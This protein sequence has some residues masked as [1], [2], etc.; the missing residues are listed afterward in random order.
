MDATEKTMRA[1]VVD[2]FGPA[3]NLH[4]ANVPL[5]QLFT[6]E[7]LVKVAAAGINPIDVKTR[8]GRGTASGFS[9]FPAVLGHDFAGVVAQPPYEAHPLAEGT[10]VFGMVS[11][12]RYSG[13]F[14]EYV[15]ANSLAVA[16]KPA[17]LTL[18]EAAAVPLA[19]LTAWGAVVDVAEAH[20]GQRMLIHAGAGG[21]GHFAVQFARHFGAE[22]ITTAS[23]RNADW[24]RE[25]GA[26]VVVD[27]TSTR[28]E[29]VV[30]DVDVVIDL[31]GNVH[32]DTA[33]RSLR[34]LKPGGLIVNVPSG[35]WPSMR[36][37]SDAAGMR[38]TRFKL[39]ADGAILA[40]I[41]ELIDAGDVRVN[42]DR[43][44]P[45]EEAAAANRAL[46]EGHTRGK[47]VLTLP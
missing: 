16:P 42:I 29:D 12:P 2:E 39:T 33:T 41:G 35:S 34:V 23:A 10:E 22:V 18:T 27:Y 25:L 45:L 19:S 44:F 31:I 4:M 37:E 20:E 6:G 21:V 36:E 47:I 26:S 24:L 9:R 11:P 3:E 28:F 46:E 15:A 38:S 17:S 43:T 40:R 7:L 30:G 5:P 13:S 1:A 32:D 14:A 8:A